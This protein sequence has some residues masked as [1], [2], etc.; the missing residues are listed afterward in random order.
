[1]FLDFAALSS[2]MRRL[3]KT[4]FFPGL[5]TVQLLDIDSEDIFSYRWARREG[6]MWC[7]WML[8]LQDRDVAFVDRNDVLLRTVP[9]KLSPPIAID[10]S[11]AHMHR[12]LSS[13][14]R[15]VEDEA[16]LRER[17]EILADGFLLDESDSEVGNI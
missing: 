14:H 11:R 17:E 15:S 13:I 2:T 1:M 3:A 12:W 6:S 8:A 9:P 5:E 10:P 4:R 7:C 16:R